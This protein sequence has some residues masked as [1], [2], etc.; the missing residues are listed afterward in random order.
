MER[1]IIKKHGSRQR[2]FS[3]WHMNHQFKY[4]AQKLDYN[5]SYLDKQNSSPGFDM[6][7]QTAL[8]F[9]EENPSWLRRLRR[10]VEIR[11]LLRELIPTLALQ[12]SNNPFL[13]FVDK[14]NTS[15]PPFKIEDLKIVGYTAY[16]CEECLISHP[17]ALYWDN[18]S[19]K[20]VPTMHICSNERIIEVQQEIHKKKEVT[21][22]LFGE[23]LEVTFLVVKQ[24]TRA[25][26][27]L[28]VAEIPSMLQGL[29]NFKVIDI[30][31]WAIRAIRNRSTLLSEEELADFLNLANANTYAYFKV[32]GQ[33]TAYNMYIGAS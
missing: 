27:L 2:V 25:R 28:K 3:N 33:N 32:K 13:R 29:Q 19:M 11:S 7:M 6:P 20:P 18:F 5:S 31:N 1:H 23:I 22:A 12:P 24:W 16:I 17:L 4:K 9:E 26:P 8:T 14:S 15:L 21:A 30:K 10:L